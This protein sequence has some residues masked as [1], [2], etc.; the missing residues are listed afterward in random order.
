MLHD[1]RVKAK[2]THTV[3]INNALYTVVFLSRGYMSSNGRHSCRQETDTAASSTADSTAQLCVKGKLYIFVAMHSCTN[4]VTQ[5]KLPYDLTRQIFWG[6]DCRMCYIPN[7]SSSQGKCMHVHSS[8]KRSFCCLYNT[9][10]ASG[11]RPQPT[12]S[13]CSHTDNSTELINVR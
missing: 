1:T 11:C 12:V 10:L 9:R 7:A 8:A 5:H 13:V 4:G 6:S 2:T 3:H